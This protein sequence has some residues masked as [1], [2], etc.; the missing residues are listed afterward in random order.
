M[1][2]FHFF[3]DGRI[4]GG[5]DIFLAI[6][7]FLFTAMLLREA[8]EYAGRV[9]LLRY[10]GRLSRRIVAPAAVVVIATTAI[11]LAVLP[12]TRHG[13]LW[14]EARA[15]LLYFENIEL[16]NSQLAYG[17][18]GPESS[19]FQ[20][21]WSLS[22]QGQFYL[23]WPAVAVVAVLLAR[24]LKV[25]AARVMAIIVGMVLVASLA[26]AIYVGFFE[27][28]R[29]YLMTTTRMWQLAF[30]GLLAL[31]G[32]RVNLPARLRGPGGWMGLALIAACG[33]VLDG[34]ALFPGLWSLWP[35]MGLALVL[36]AGG[37]EGG[38]KDP[39]SSATRFL[40]HRAFAWI[41]DHAYALYLWHWPVLIYYL[42]I[43]D[44]EAIGPRGAAFV[45]TV[46]LVLT[47]FTHRW[48]ETPLKNLQTKA[49]PTVATRMKRINVVTVAG[50]M[51]VLVGGG[52]VT[53]A[54]IA[55]TTAPTMAEDWDWETY[56][57]GALDP[58]QSVPQADHVPG[59]AELPS[60]RPDYYAWGCKQPATQSPATAAIKVCEDPDKPAEPSATVVLAGGSH[61][62]HWAE[63]FRQLAGRH[64]WE[65]LVVDRSSCPFGEPVDP[66][67]TACATWQD[68][69][70]SWLEDTGREIDLVVTPGSR[71]QASRGE[72]IMPGAQERWQQITDAGSRLLLLRGTPRGDRNVATCLGEGTAPDDCG[73]PVE[74]IASDS[75]LNEHTMPEGASTVD[76]IDHVCPAVRE[77]AERCDAVVGNVVIWHDSHHLTNAYAGT[78][79]PI[80]E[81]RMREA[82]PR[83]FR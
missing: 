67:D 77:D 11:G 31:W 20:H 54:A 56:P 49:G 52:A 44:R 79:V 29:A 55:S 2:L 69:F 70:I 68:N 74:Q 21:F 39:R 78:M 40:S 15:S 36:A 28:D 25:P 30:G 24:H 48:V 61:A 62:G 23:V 17:A 58:G 60:V 81:T 3:G 63:T 35:L 32:A 9:N 42:E 45:L 19:P 82:V 64:R 18:A 71:L 26:V 73:P 65:L 57:G 37:A 50:I 6:S 16:I 34:A 75:P 76:V 1:V 47:W 10:F 27:Q 80:M 4:S 46:S 13:Q 51:V 53:T 83:L 38:S 59:L 22:V 66:S 12:V 43:R 33:F 72:F 5:I 41:G 14:T 8:T 7:G